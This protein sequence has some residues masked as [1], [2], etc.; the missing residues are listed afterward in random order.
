MKRD[1]GFTLIELLVVITII[2]IL[3]AFLLPSLH[4]AKDK[5]HQSYCTNNLHQ[6]QLA[7]EMYQSD[8]GTLPPW[9]SNMEKYIKARKV[10]QCLS[11]PSRGRQGSRPPW[12]LPGI[13]GDQRYPETWD[14][15]G[16]GAAASSAGLSGFDYDAGAM[17]NPWL[18]ANSYLYEWCAAECSWWTGGMYPDPSNPGQ[19]HDASDARVDSNRDGKI[20]WREARQFE[21]PICG[22][23]TPIISCYWHTQSAGALVVRAAAGNKNIYTS[24]ATDDGWKRLNE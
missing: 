10:F 15:E 21:L 11:D 7:L 18:R 2:G 13:N 20:S 19:F 4:T 22:P 16:A 8:A 24:D 3:A 23:Q 14:F 12:R 6:M 9:L 5:A 17:Q 1:T